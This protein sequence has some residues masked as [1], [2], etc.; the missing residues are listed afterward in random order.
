MKGDNKITKEELIEYDKKVRRRAKKFK[1][2]SEDAHNLYD[3]Y[4]MVN[5]PFETKKGLIK[6]LKINK[7]DKWFHNFTKRIEKIVQGKNIA[8]DKKIK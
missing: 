3:L 5:S 2:K 8:F 6:T 4:W 1:L 7:M